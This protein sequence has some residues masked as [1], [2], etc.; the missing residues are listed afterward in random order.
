MRQRFFNNNPSAPSEFEEAVLDINRVSKKT[1]GGN[2]ARFSA[3]VVVGDKKNRVAGSLA[4]AR[5]VRAAIAKAVR[6]AKKKFI[7]VPIV[8]GTIPFSVT[9]KMGG[10]KV[11]LKPAPPGSGI[12][13]GG[14]VRTILSLSGV[15]DASGKILG[16]RNKVGNVYATMEALKKL[17]VYS[18]NARLHLARR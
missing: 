17:I 4:K 13:A 6:A 2:Q 16:S 14:V 10:A 1:Q 15:K 11:L 3:L 12:I 9:A 5:D 8:G 7:E 18:K